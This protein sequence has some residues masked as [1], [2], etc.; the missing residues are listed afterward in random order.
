[1]DQILKCCQQ[2]HVSMFQLCLTCYYIYLYKLTNG[3]Q[4]LCICSVHANRHKPDLL[5]IIAESQQLAIILDSQSLTYAEM[6]Y[7]VQQVSLHFIDKYHVKSQ[8]I[9]C[10]CIE[11]SI[12]MVI[13]ILAISTTGYVYCPLSPNDPI[14][15]LYH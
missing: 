10:Q 5:P 4:D 14:E 8:Q 2:Y 13:G 7:Y 12:E 3:D 6:L 11:R 1:M 9:I 15:R